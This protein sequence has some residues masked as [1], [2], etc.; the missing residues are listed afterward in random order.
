MTGAEW[1]DVRAAIGGAW[2]ALESSPAEIAIVVGPEQILVFQNA[3]S[4]QL[5]GPFMLGKP[6]AVSVPGAGHW[7]IYDEVMREGRVIR[8]EPRAVGPHDA[9]GGELVMR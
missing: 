3:A 4:R 1:G 6:L 8:A 9:S 5:F 2:Q 7:E